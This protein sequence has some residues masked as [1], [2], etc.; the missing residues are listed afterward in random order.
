MS[1]AKSGGPALGETSGVREPFDT[2]KDASE[3]RAKH[4]FAVDQIG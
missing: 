1:Q 4:M 3:T 2:Y